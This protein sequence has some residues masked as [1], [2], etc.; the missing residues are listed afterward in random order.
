MSVIVEKQID[1][2][3]T[4]TIVVFQDFSVFGA[5]LFQNTDYI[6]GKVIIFHLSVELIYLRIV[7]ALDSYPFT[8]KVLFKFIHVFRLSTVTL[9]YK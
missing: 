7:D 9:I 5:A 1:V 6:N 3:E 8:K 4:V 2:C